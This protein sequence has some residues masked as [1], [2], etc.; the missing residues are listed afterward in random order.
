M[1]TNIRVEYRHIYIYILRIYSETSR[2]LVFLGLLAVLWAFWLSSG[3]SGPPLEGSWDLPGLSWGGP[4][5]SLCVL[6]AVKIC[7]FEHVQNDRLFSVLGWAS[8]APCG[9]SDGPWGPPGGPGGLWPFH[10]VLPGPSWGVQGVLWVLLGDPRGSCFRQNIDR[11]ID[12]NHRTSDP[13]SLSRMDCFVD[14]RIS[15]AH[16]HENQY[17]NRIYLYIYI[18]IYVMHVCM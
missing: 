2:G 10:G 4:G 18:Y 8:G 1:K 13:R 9:C 5:V 17:Q 15:A 16:I 11:N 14:I 3:C 7:C 6:W 12:R